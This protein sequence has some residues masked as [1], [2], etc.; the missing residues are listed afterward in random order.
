M[1]KAKM[2]W[3]ELEG[4]EHHPVVT[5]NSFQAVFEKY[6]VW[7]ENKKESGLSDRTIK[8]RKIYWRFLAPV[9]GPMN[10]DDIRPAQ[11]MP[12]Y[13]RRSSKASAKKEIKFLSVLCNWAIARGYMT[14]INPVTGLTRQMKV[15]E[16]QKNICIQ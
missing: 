4:Q 14:V 6:M 10:I 1:A 16:K 3:A 12:Y 8:D 7:A 11:I 2:R 5:E 13:Y 9:Y 15:D